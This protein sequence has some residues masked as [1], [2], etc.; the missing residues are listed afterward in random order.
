MEKYPD[1][2]RLVFAH[3]PLPMHKWARPAAIAA[4]CAARQSQSAFWTLHDAYFANQGGLTTDN[5]LAKSAEYLAETDVAMD[6]WRTCAQDTTS[7]AHEEAA[8]AVDRTTQIGKELGVTGTPAFFLNGKMI[9]GAQPLE[10]FEQHL[11]TAASSDQ[12]REE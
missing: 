5:V 4:Q 3:Y 11:Q 6:Q 1:R 10:V 2:I 8:T 7:S 9:E 12:A